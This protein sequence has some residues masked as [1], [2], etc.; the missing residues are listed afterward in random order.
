[1]HEQKITRPDG[2]YPHPMT[3]LRERPEPPTRE[4]TTHLHEMTTLTE[5]PD[6]PI[7]AEYPHEMTHLPEHA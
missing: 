6:T 7:E 4:H 3:T 5:Q 2:E 1:M